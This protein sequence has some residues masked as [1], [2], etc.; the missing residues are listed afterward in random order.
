MDISSLFNPGLYKITCLKNNKIYI[1]ISSNVLSRLGRHTD[2]LENNR[3]DCLEL[4]Q[5]FHQFG[6]KSF[7]FEA[8]ETHSKFTN[9]KLKKREILLIN[10]IPKSFRYNKTN[11][12]NFF[13]ARAI[14]VNNKVYSS[15]SYAAKTLNESRTH[16]VRKCLN[17]NIKNYEF[18]EYETIKKYQFHKPQS[19]VIDD[20]FYSSLNQAAKTLKISH[21]TVKN[22]ILSEKYSNY[23]FFNEVDR[24]ND[25]PEKE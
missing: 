3:H 7:I 1:G 8:L 5:D 17:K 25:Y 24:S 12:I 21:K 6:K 9:E 13:G 14:K 16:L 23:E 19:C 4:Q 20:V 10:Q 2:N 11:L 15:L 22:R 18:V